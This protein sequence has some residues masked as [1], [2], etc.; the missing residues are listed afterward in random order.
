MTLFT[1]YYSSV[2]SSLFIHTGSN[3]PQKFCVDRVGKDSWLPRSHTWW[4]PSCVVF[5]LYSSSD[6]YM[7][8]I[9]ISKYHSISWYNIGF[10]VY[11]YTRADNLVNLVFL[12]CLILYLNNKLVCIT[13]IDFF[14][15]FLTTTTKQGII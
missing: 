10:W 6:V 4:V 14:Y 7:I 1:M 11:R 8:H 15:H 5:P 12:I 13:L 3:G 2:V 9:H